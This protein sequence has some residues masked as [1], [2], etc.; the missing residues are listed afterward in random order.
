MKCVRR[1]RSSLSIA[2]LLLTF[3]AINVVHHQQPALSQSSDVAA[4]E[5]GDFICYIEKSDG[6]I[7]NL[8]KLCDKG[9][10]GSY[11]TVS[12][13]DQRFLENYQRL[14]RKR[15]RVSPSVQTALSQIQQNPQA[16]VQRAQAVCTAIRTGE[17]QN[18]QPPGQVDADIFD[19]LAPKYYCPELNN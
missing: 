18:L 12:T 1:I 17:P 7:V 15:L 4:I 6:R 16:A 8:N 5:P 19:T 10:S 14:L 13:T 9:R 2:S 11:A 3:S